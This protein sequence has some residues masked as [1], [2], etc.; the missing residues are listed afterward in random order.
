MNKSK[1]KPRHTR[2][3]R[4]VNRAIINSQLYKKEH[5]RVYLASN[6][7]LLSRL[8]L[9]PENLKE[10]IKIEK[11]TIRLNEALWRCGDEKPI[12]VALARSLL[13]T[14]I[15]QL[16]AFIESQKSYLNQSQLNQLKRMRENLPRQ[17][18][19]LQKHLSKGVIMSPQVLRDIA[20]IN[21]T[22]LFQVLGRENFIRYL[23]HRGKV[24]KVF[25]KRGEKLA[26]IYR[27][28]S[29]N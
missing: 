19:G 16:P 1:P 2:L 15:S 8:K 3:S 17:L 5:R 12:S 4:E 29:L 11:N 21:S 24:Q 20:M 26:E 22:S 14:A 18:E 6:R 27:T 28:A 7:V 13:K 25:E 10:A 9:S 23:K